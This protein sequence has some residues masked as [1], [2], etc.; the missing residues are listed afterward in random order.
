MADNTNNNQVLAQQNLQG[1][2]QNDE[3]E[4]DL[5]QLFFELRKNI[6]KIILA[7]IVGG[8]IAGAFSKFVLTP[9]YRSTAM[10]YILSKETTLTSLADLQ[11]GAQLTNDYKTI[12]TSRPVL[13]KTV[14]DLGLPY[15]YRSLNSKITVGNPTNTRIIT[16]TAEDPSPE[17][18]KQIADKVAT[19]SSDFI[20]DIMEMVPPKMIESG[21]IP[22]MKSSPSNARTALIGAM[23]G[24]LIVSGLVVINM[25]LNDTIVTTD[26]VTN[27]LGVSVLASIPTREVV[28]EEE[29]NEKKGLDRSSKKS[30]KKKK[31][32]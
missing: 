5:L 21:E 6:V 10:M 17:M 23:V 9:Q 15:G 28:T 8:V 13:Q 4:I 27:Y 30:R 32:K 11:I 19:T 25:L 7:A 26:D 3:V 31:L 2:F 24:V 29:K 22:T 16:I 1:R 18:A 12:V 14:E 20:G